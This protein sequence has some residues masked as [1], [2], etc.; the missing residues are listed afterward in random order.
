MRCDIYRSKSRNDIFFI[1][2]TGV[3]PSQFLQ[4]AIAQVGE[5][6]FVKTREFVSGQ[7][8]IGA[9]SDEV[10]GNVERFGFHVQGIKTKTEVSEGGLRWE[11]AYLEQALRGPWVL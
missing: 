5:L 11:G 8:L 3:K 1:V 10:I 4:G 2:K 6:E 9:S 7:P